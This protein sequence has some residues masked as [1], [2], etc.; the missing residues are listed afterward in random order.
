MSK[1]PRRL[2]SK[3]LRAVLWYAADGKCQLCG[4]ELDP[5]NWHADH[6][7]PWVKSQRTNVFEMQALCP[8]CNLKKGR[9]DD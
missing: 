2:A 4:K 6:V 9:K 7:V 3:K 8:A 1:Q 5:A